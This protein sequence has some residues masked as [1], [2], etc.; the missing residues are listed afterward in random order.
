MK[1]LIIIIAMFC[2]FSALKA[3]R[4][5]GGGGHGI[6]KCKD[7]YAYTTGYND[8]G[9]LGI[10]SSS[11][12]FTFVQVV[13]IPPITDI[14]A[15]A[16]HTL[17]LDTGGNVWAWGDNS[18]GQLCDSSYVNRIMPHRVVGVDKILSISAGWRFSLYLREDSTVWAGGENTNGQVGT[19]SPPYSVNYLHQISNLSDVISISAGFNHCLALKAD[20]SVWSW[21]FN[22]YGQLGDGTTN[23]SIIPV[24]VQGL[25]SIVAVEAGW[26]VSYAIKNDGTLWSWGANYHG[27]L[28]TGSPMGAGVTSSPQLVVGLDSVSMIR[29]DVDFTL[30]LKEKGSV[31]AWGKNFHG[32]L[33]DGTKAD[34]NVPTKV[35][36][37]SSVVDVGVGS[38]V[39]YAINSV[40]KIYSWGAG[41]EGALASDTITQKLTPSPITPIACNPVVSLYEKKVQKTGIKVYPNP[42]SGFITLEGVAGAKIE[43]VEVYN[44]TGVSVMKVVKPENRIDISALPK[45][46]YFIQCE[47]D[48]EVVVQKILKE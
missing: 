43:S 1:K 6:V 3:Q 2:G 16:E 36:N 17:V 15:G 47:V 18:Y 24:Q 31:W 5:D 26:S 42:A 21:G 25:N 19:Q 11:S 7:G 48:G 35:K 45:G 33:G 29:S 20:G 10:G 27:Q 30:A 23:T 37:L 4:I 46:I 28:G 13:G 41:P 34:R 9:Q 44:T 38:A 12:E 8:K 14:A 40:G 22:S 39:G 32:Q